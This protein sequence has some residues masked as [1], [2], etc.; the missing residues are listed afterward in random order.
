[1]L[2]LTDE[3]VIKYDSLIMSIV[4]KFAQN[5]NREDLYQ[6]GRNA[7]LKASLKYDENANVKFSTFSYKYILGE[8]LKYIREDKNLHVSRDMIRLNRNIKVAEERYYMSYG[9]YPS[10]YELSLLLK[11]NENKIKEV[12]NLCQNTDSLDEKNDYGDNELSLYDVTYDKDKDVTFYT[13][14]NACIKASIMTA[15]RNT[16]TWK[17]RIL[18]TSY[19]LDKMYED[20]ESNFYDLFK[21]ERE[22]PNRK[23]IDREETLELKNKIT[24]KLSDKEKV[25]FDLK[26]KGLDNKEIADLIDKDKKYVENTIFRIKKKYKELEIER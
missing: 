4:N 15:I 20:S 19:S 13:Y 26:L 21:D 7:L 6:V 18:N 25:I 23:L 14:A 10:S 16:F 11:E 12:L 2:K 24:S 9:K 17:N 22:E 5:Y 3:L 1:M 8:I